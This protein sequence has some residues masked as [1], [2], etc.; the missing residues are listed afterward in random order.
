MRL[1]SSVPLVQIEDAIRQLS[2][3]E[4]LWLIERLVHGLRHCSRGARPPSNTALAEMAAD[5]E[6]RRELAQ[7]AQ[8]F[9]L[10]EMDGLEQP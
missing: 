3:D 6:M 2:Y 4:R 9:T 5:P 7:I 8:E 1:M 10:A